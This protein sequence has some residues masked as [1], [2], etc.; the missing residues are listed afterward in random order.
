MVA[1]KGNKFWVARARHGRRPRFADSESLWISC[2]DYFDWVEAHPLKE[3]KIF[4]WQGKV[5]STEV[6]KMRAMTINGLCLHLGIDITTWRDYR[7]KNGFSSVSERVEQ[8]I[9]EQKFTGAAAGLFNTS[10]IA[11]DLGL[12]NKDEVK[13]LFTDR[14]CGELNTRLKTLL[15]LYKQ[16]TA[17]IVDT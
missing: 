1:P 2:V 11:R 10:I 3:E 15:S 7:K 17:V 13:L 16:N 14:P 6:S 5:I 4:T 9:Y 8:I 12:A